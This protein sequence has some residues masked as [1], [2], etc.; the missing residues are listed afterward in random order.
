MIF[1]RR[2]YN[3]AVKFETSKGCLN[4]HGTV[5]YG[6]FWESNSLEVFDVIFQYKHQFLPMLFV[7]AR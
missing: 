1:I 3:I 6:L 2:E 4:K 7:L 5:K